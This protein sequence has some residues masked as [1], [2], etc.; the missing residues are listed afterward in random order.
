MALQNKTSYFVPGSSP[1]KVGNRGAWD[2]IVDAAEGAVNTVE[3]VYHTVVPPVQALGGYI[4]EII[5][6]GGIDEQ[7]Q[8][9]MG[10]PVRP[11]FRPDGQGYNPADGP[12]RP[13]PGQHGGFGLPWERPGL[14]GSGG[15]FTEALQDMNQDAYEQAT[16]SPGPADNEIVLDGTPV[17][18]PIAPVTLDASGRPEQPDFFTMLD[19][20]GNLLPQFQ[21]ESSY[22]YDDLNALRDFAQGT[23]DSPWAQAALN[24]AGLAGDAAR[25]L[26]TR[27]SA[28]DTQQAYEQLAMR[29]GVGGGAWERMAQQGSRGLNI[30]QQE[31]ARDQALAEANIR[32]AD[33]AAR[34]QVM[35]SL[36][37]MNLQAAVYETGIDQTNVATTSQEQAAQNQLSMA[38]WQQMMED[39]TAQQL[40]QN[41]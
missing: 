18:A 17:A 13:S 9:G 38:I 4:Q 6:G 19:E 2:S 33:T 5:P 22:N 40:A 26:A 29:G 7:Q 25:D 16:G 39:Y 14:H 20:D 3:D 34:Q 1:S 30:A 15:T 32:A 10:D 11:V 12:I 23:G 21:V 35:T 31:A 27:Q 24:Q 8:G 41:L 37:G 28:R 36:P